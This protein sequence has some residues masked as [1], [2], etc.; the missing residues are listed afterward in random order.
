MTIRRM[1][2]VG[3]V[4]DDLA[5]AV[6]FFATL[7]L[8]LQGEA[9]VEGDWVDRIVGLEGVQAQIAMLRTPDGHGR[10][11]LTK[12]HTPSGRGGEE[13]AP[14][15]AA[16]IRHVAFAVEDIDAV[17]ASLR[18]RGAELV[19]GVERYEDRYRLCYVRGPEGIIVEL[20]EQI[21]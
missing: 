5:E 8:E 20:A 12:F 6:A 3:I 19:G 13:H 10:L 16:G 14:A 7:G 18:A 9:P 1:D 15:N 21:G 4:V 2:H 11:E 17:L